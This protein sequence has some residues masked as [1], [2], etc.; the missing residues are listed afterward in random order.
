M[1]GKGWNLVF[2]FLY[3]GEFFQRHLLKALSIPFLY[4][5]ETWSKSIDHVSLGLFLSFCSISLVDGSIS[6]FHGIFPYVQV[7]YTG[8]QSGTVNPKHLFSQ[9]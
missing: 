9:I 2:S 5:L 6:L 3:N 7:A 1:C 4:A 8:S